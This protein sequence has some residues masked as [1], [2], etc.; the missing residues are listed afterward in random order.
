MERSTNQ[1]WETPLSAWR[2]ICK[3]IGTH[4]VLWDPF[5]CE[6][7]SRIYLQD[8]GYEVAPA[9]KCTDKTS[10]G[11]CDCMNADVPPQVTCMITNPPF[12]EIESTVEWFIKEE[13]RKWV[14]L[15]PE[16][17]VS[18]QWFKEAMRTLN[19]KIVRPRNKIHYISKGKIMEGCPF[20]S[21]WIMCGEFNGMKRKRSNE[22]DDEMIM[23]NFEGL[24]D[25]WK[26]FQDR[27]LE[28]EEV[29]KWRDRQ[30]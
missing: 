14:L 23:R 15:V 13:D 1:D 28:E 9:D 12:K 27:E 8:L 29:S 16:V 10:N 25:R 5:V 3:H 17:I 18:R 4:E 20:E 24:T 6:G 30:R 22:L 26:R 11:T 19:Y 2:E 21:V 7:R